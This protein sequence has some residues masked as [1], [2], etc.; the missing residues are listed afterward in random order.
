MKYAARLEMIETIPFHV[1]KVCTLNPSD[2]RMYVCKVVQ[3]TPWNRSSM[4]L[5]Q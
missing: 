2:V 5:I 3:D 4:L 1:E